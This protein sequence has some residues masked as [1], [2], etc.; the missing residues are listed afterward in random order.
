M[1]TCQYNECRQEEQWAQHVG[2]NQS[3]D[4]DLKEKK[5][6]WTSV[7]GEKVAQTSNGNT[8]GYY[9]TSSV[10]LGKSQHAECLKL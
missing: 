10:R 1:L 8:W 9:S 6:S 4:K 5:H 3:P 7:I 2:G